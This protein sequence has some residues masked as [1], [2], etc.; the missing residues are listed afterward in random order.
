MFRNGISHEWSVRQLI[1]LP[2]FCVASCHDDE[3]QI[4]F[5]TVRSLEIKEL[6][7]LV[8][9]P[10]VNLH[11]RLAAGQ[12][13]ALCG[14]PRLG[15][16]NPQMVEIPAALSV[17]VGLPL[18]HLDEVHGKY[19]DLGVKREWL[20]KECP[21]YLID[22]KPFKIS[23]YLVTNIEF[24][25]F[26][27]DSGL[28][29]L[30]SSWTLGRYPK[31]KS[32]HPVHSV[33]PDAADAYISWLQNKTNRKYRLPNEAEWEFAAA[34]PSSFD[35]PWGDQFHNGFANTAELGLLDTSPVGCFPEGNSPFG[36]ADVAGNVEEYVSD[37]YAPYPGGR[38]IVD[39]LYLIDAN[40]RIARGGSFSRFRD[41]ARTKRRHGWYSNSPV[42]AMGFRLAEDI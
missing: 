27:L 29:F 21:Q 33:S 5:S 37:T 40:Y 31:E 36:L 38:L 14:D 16:L 18:E 23:K 2:D 3:V 17:R 34:G 42:Y 4:A 39:D 22:L 30:P 41:L 1:G 6:L 32:N 10:L 26:L 11:I 13:L 24:Y 28:S 7:R 25:R 9:S 19:A 15:Y 8:E 20:E 12:I 35:F